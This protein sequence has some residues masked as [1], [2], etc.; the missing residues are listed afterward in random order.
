MPIKKTRWM[1]ERWARLCKNLCADFGPASAAKIIET[2][3]CAIGGERVTIPSQAD[4]Q[5]HK[6]NRQIYA[7]FRGDYN[8]ISARFGISVDIARRVVMQQRMIERLKNGEDDYS[9]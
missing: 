4:L 7:V 9:P 5:R 8:E 6:R 2:I 3:V 1:E